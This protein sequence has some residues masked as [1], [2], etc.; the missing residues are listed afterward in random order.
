MVNAG[1]FP[2]TLSNPVSFHKIDRFVLFRLQVG[3]LCTVLL[4]QGT[5][6]KIR[7]PASI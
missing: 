1:F 6:V 7:R 2:R 4:A 5:G 3:G